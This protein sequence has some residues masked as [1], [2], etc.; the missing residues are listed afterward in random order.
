MIAGFII[1]ETGPKRVILR[2]IGPSLSFPSR[3]ADPVLELYNASGQL[4][5]SN[6]DWMQNANQQAINDS[7]VAPSNPKEPALLVSLNPGLYTAIV[8]GKNNTSGIG[9]IEAYDLD[10]SA[11]AQIVNISTRGFVQTNDNVLIGG[12]IITGSDPSDVVIRALGPS[13][14]VPNVLLDPQLELFNSNGDPIFMNDDWKDTQQVAIAA[15][16]LQPTN[17]KESAIRISLVPGNYTAIVRGAGGATGIRLI[18][19]YKLA[20]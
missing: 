16:Q 14:P 20:P 2:G 13:I 19:F 15:S 1:Q 17:D 4:I 12:T 9:L 10:Q 5:T 11:A 8:R 6:D 7:G 3:L 18:E